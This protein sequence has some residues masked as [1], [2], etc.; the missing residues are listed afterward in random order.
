MSFISDTLANSFKQTY[1]NG[2]LD[3]SGNVLLRAGN[4]IIGNLDYPNFNINN[5]SLHVNGGTTFNGNVTINSSTTTSSFLSISSQTGNSIAIGRGAVANGSNS[6]AIGNEATRSGIKGISL[7]SN[8]SGSGTD[9]IAIGTDANT[10]S[11]TNSTAIGKSAICNANNQIVLGTASEQVFCGGTGFNESHQFVV[12]ANTAG[13]VCNSTAAHG[14]LG[15]FQSKAPFVIADTGY[16]TYG[17]K[18]E[19]GLWRDTGNAYIQCEASNSGARAIVMQP[20]N[21]FVG[22]G[23][24]SPTACLDVNGDIKASSLILNTITP[25]YTTI[26]TYTSSMIGY[27]I[28]QTNTLTNRSNGVNIDGSGISLPIGVYMISS[29]AHVANTAP[30]FY[31]LSLVQTAVVVLE[32]T[33]NPAFG[34]TSQACS[35]IFTIPVVVS[36][37]SQ[38]YFT[39]VNVLSPAA[40]IYNITLTTRAVR[41]A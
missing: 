33:L 25:L 28:T 37:A 34:N 6:I 4:V 13:R 17:I 16:S 1:V 22:I 30:T 7:G 24:I 32:S 40:V 9:S 15:D 12:Q 5:K 21:G 2:F 36:S 29:K 10:S 35:T 41:I 20:Y 14:G 39:R 3:C 27:T 38:S 8:T 19:M 11:F 26:P 23:T 18:L 31:T